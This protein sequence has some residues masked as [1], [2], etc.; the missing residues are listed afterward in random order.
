MVTH[1]AG[2][3]GSGVAPVGPL[4]S[5][6]RETPNADQHVV[7]AGGSQGEGDRD[8]EEGVHSARSRTYGQQAGWHRNPGPS[9]RCR[10]HAFSLRD[11][12]G[13][14]PP[15]SLHLPAYPWD[16]RSHCG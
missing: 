15:F 2:N 7:V 10:L 4:T 16:V 13:E 14:A 6:R 9:P 5:E 3:D 1:M 8:I 12:P 11:S